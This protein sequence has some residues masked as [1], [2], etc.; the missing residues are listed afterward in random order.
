MSGS[1][2]A[3]SVYVTLHVLNLKF[4]K[5]TA[6][7]IM[8]ALNHTKKCM[9][10][11]HNVACIHFKIKAAASN[12]QKINTTQNF[13]NRLQEILKTIHCKVV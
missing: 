8:D 6:T 9:C 4:I 11:D 5:D 12:A 3:V 10:C 2:I 13:L 7:I 1:S